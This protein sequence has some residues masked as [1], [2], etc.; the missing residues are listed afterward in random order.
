M[1]PLFLDIDGVLNTSE[2]YKRANCWT[3]TPEAAIQLFEPDMVLR[4]Q[5]ICDSTGAII[6]VSSTWRFIFSPGDI[7]RIFNKVGLTAP[8]YGVTPKDKANR[9]EAIE[10]W[11]KQNPVSAW[12]AIDDDLESFR[13]K[14][15]LMERLVH[16]DGDVGITDADAERAMKLLKEKP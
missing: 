14:F 16:V 2:T 9:A 1:I 12:C 13:F 8:V 15:H 5:R 10:L 3:D 4:V 11:L 6:V 7:K